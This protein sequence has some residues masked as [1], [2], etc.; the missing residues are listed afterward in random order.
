MDL[1][2]A[3][4]RSPFQVLAPYSL[5][6]NRIDSIETDYV[7]TRLVFSPSNW[8]LL[9]NGPGRLSKPLTFRM[10]REFRDGRAYSQNAQWRSVLGELR[11]LFQAARD[12]CNRHCRAERMPHNHNFID[13]VFADSL[14]NTAGEVVNSR[15]HF[16]SLT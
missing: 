10:Q 3:D 7:I 5:K 13:V 6:G 11:V 16:R 2:T 8:H 1:D 12:C 15:F 9:G 14:E 4:I